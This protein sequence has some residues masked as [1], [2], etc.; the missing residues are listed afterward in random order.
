MR[1]VGPSG[2]TFTAALALFVFSSCNDSK[3][4]VYRVEKEREPQTSQPSSV[5]G[6]SNGSGEVTWQAPADWEEQPATGPRKG[7]FKIHGPDG[8][9]AEL[10]ITSFPG[11]VGGLL[12]NVNRWR[13]QIQLPPIAETDLAQAVTPVSASGRTISLVDLV[14]A[15]PVKDGKKSRVLGGALALDNETWFFK[16]SGPDELV[17]AKKD[18]FRKFL[19]TIKVE[20]APMLASAAGNTGSNTNAPTPPP[21]SAAAPPLEYKA[22]AGWV[23]QPLTPMRLA[24]FKVMGANGA[25]ADVSVVSLAGMAGGD[26]ANI[27]RW[28]EQLK[29][30]PVGES[31]LSAISSHVNANGHDFLITDLVSTEALPP[32]NRKMRILAAASQQGEQTWFVKMT[33]D[34]D[35]VGTQK[36]HFLDFLQKLSISS[37]T[38]SDDSS[39]Q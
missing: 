34:V 13:G 37:A 31:E 4:E 24:S 30:P 38:R 35:L 9:E 39:V 16:L 26:L 21:L 33:G 28:R 12:A 27:N 3:I 36:K 32:A 23:A 5:S 25:E 11:D 19:Q 22:P 18:E 29:L 1:F 7:T 10:S 20:T 8:S 14:S 6:E 17:T 15:G 2:A